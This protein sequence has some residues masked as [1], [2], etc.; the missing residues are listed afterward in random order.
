MKSAISNSNTAL[1]RKDVE[2]HLFFFLV[3][4]E[5]NVLFSYHVKLE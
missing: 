4:L 5:T 2:T 3:Q 1:P